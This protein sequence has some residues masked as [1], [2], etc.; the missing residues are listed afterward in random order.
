MNKFRGDFGMQRFAK[1]ISI[2]AAVVSLVLTGCS[3]TVSLSD[4]MTSKTWATLTQTTKLNLI[5]GFFSAQGYAGTLIT[6]YDVLIKLTTNYPIDMDNSM[7]TTTD[8]IDIG[9]GEILI[10][11]V[12][13]VT[14]S[15]SPSLGAQYIISVEKGPEGVFLVADDQN[16]AIRQALF[17]ILQKVKEHKSSSLT[18][19]MV[20]NV[21]DNYENAMTQGT[22][23]TKLVLK[24][25]PLYNDTIKKL[26]SYAKQGIH[27]QLLSFELK[28]LQKTGSQSYSAITNSTY[29][30]VY[31]DGSSKKL[32]EV[33]KYGI[34]DVNGKPLLEGRFI[35]NTKVLSST[36]APSSTSSNTPSS[37]QNGNVC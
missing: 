20:G 4:R 37:S 17:K 27:G 21:I 2:V 11:H 10:A 15:M 13:H 6:P 19:S 3:Q 7:A 24:G 30:I 36:L 5:K 35:E 12:L 14:S 9:A 31:S 8:V 25:S 23:P 32:R 33:I 16:R 18:S 29:T 28:S 26:F 1:L 34:S 22:V